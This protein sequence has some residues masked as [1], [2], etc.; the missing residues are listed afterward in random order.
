ME[1]ETNSFHTWGK[2]KRHHGPSNDRWSQEQRCKQNNNKKICLAWKILGDLYRSLL[3][4]KLHSQ[5]KIYL[6]FK[7]ASSGTCLVFASNHGFSTLPSKATVWESPPSFL[8]S[9]N[10]ESIIVIL[11]VTCIVPKYHIVFLSWFSAAYF[12]FWLFV[13]DHLKEG[14][15]HA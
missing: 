3:T 10:Y 4:G 9:T 6:C 12:Y 14:L 15:F 1:R 8:Q 5:N 7:A 13:N 2:N 11:S